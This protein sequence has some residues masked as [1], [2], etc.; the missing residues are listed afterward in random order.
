VRK[1]AWVILL[2]VPVA[3]VVAAAV[4]AQT[5]L[6]MLD[7]GHS[8]ARIFAWQLI[9]WTF[10]AAAVPLVLRANR[11]TAHFAILGVVLIAAHSALNAGATVLVQPYQPLPAS[12]YGRAL[13]WQ[14][15]WLLPIDVV[16]YLWLVL[17]GFA[18]RLHD[19]TRRLEIRESH[20]EADLARAQLEVLRLEIQPHFLFNTLNAISALIRLKANDRA[21][22]MLVGLSELMRYT[23]DRSVEQMVQL[24]LELDYIRRYIAIQQARFG[25]R[26]QVRF[27]IA[28]ECGAITVPAFLLQPIV[29]NALRHGVAGVSRPCRVD[30][31]AALDDEG[32]LRLSIRDDG[33]GLPPGFSLD[34][35]AHT[36]LRNARARLQRLYGPGARLSVSA[37]PGGGTVTDVWLLPRRIEMAASASA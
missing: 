8:F 32:T 24:D 31:C 26:L 25:D 1:A 19:K 5:Y 29:E 21:L 36:G 28:D 17:I 20:L 37:L 33:S 12:T 2:G 3:A 15:R 22:D 23:L 16:A 9:C 30:V 34:R 13:M 18:L 11:T 27:D 6:S 35:D 7:H 14:L 4:A 10:W